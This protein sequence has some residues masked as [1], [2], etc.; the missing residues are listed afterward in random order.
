MSNTQHTPTPWSCIP[1]GNPES[2]PSWAIEFLNGFIV[3]TLG[4]NDQANAEFIVKACNCHDDLLAACKDTLADVDFYL[5]DVDWASRHK[6]WQDRVTQLRA[7]IA[8]AKPKGG[9]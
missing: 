5:T 8:K 1:P 6:N 7:A 9:E 3:S 2:N 4:G